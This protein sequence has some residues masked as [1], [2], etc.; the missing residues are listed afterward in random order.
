M[1]P[2]PEAQR[3]SAHARPFSP[4]SLPSPQRPAG[5][6]RPHLRVLPLAEGLR[7]LLPQEDAQ[8]PLPL[9]L[10]HRPLLAQLQ[11]PPVP[12]GRHGGRGSGHVTAAATTASERG[13]G[14]EGAHAQ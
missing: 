11:E 7:H 1:A 9:R 8:V 3:R 6:F 2:A 12:G 4:P 13:R 10:L 14:G 5:R